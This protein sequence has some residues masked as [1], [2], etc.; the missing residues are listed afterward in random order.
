MALV[1]RLGTWQRFSF[2]R[3]ILLDNQATFA[4]ETTK[5]NTGQRLLNNYDQINGSK[6]LI[7][8]TGKLT[9]TINRGKNTS[10]ASTEL[11]LAESSIDNIKKILDN[12][13]DDAILA[14]SDLTSESDKKILG[15]K[16]RNLGESL[17]QSSNAKIGTKYLFGGTQSDIPVITHTPGTNFSNAVYKQGNPDLPERKTENLQSSVSLS[18]LFTTQ[19]SSAVFDGLAPSVIPL[20]AD[21]EMNLMVHDGVKNINIG[22]IGFTAGDDLDTIV[23]KINSAFNTAGGQGS[24]AQNNAGKLTLDTSL[25]T[26]NI[27][28]V[29]AAVIISKGTNLPNTLSSL[30]LKE[31]TT[32]GTSTN[33]REVL[34]KL[35]DAYHSNDSSALRNLI[36]DIDENIKRLIAAQSKL[37]DLSNKFI[38][39]TNQYSDLKIDYQVKQTE[40]AKIPVVEAIEEVNKS[41]AVL[42]ATM[43]SSTQMM[44]QNIFDF[45]KL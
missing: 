11:E 30:G 16:L 15:E 38:A 23:T 6:D 44:S 43:R 25:I 33:M 8:V 41:Q 10:L 36:V 32:N 18:K 20:T 24:I 40:I 42:Q 3:G 5:L 17:F 27:K 26:G 13:K 21:A 9:E 45:L 7:A 37:G 39:K 34:S 29:S 28:N 1:G 2:N 22:N 19:S 12:L 14:S 35:D 4:R 31:I